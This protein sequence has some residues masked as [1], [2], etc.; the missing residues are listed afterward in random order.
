MK[1]IISVLGIGVLALGVAFLGAGPVLAAEKTLDVT[2]TFDGA[3]TL[4]PAGAPADACGATGT[5]LAY[6]ALNVTQWDN[7]H[8]LLSG[9]LRID[10]VAV[11]GTVIARAQ[12]TA[13]QNVGTGGLPLVIQ[14]NVQM[15][16]VGGGGPVAGVA[17]HVGLTVDGNGAVHLR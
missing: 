11:D 10:K 2:T 4:P 8:T 17:T 16:C 14:V 12:Q 13:H 5:Y 6:G 1:T 3:P 7:G 9:H 15:H